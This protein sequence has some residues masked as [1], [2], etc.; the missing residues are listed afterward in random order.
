MGARDNLVVT[1]AKAVEE[2]HARE[3]ALRLA[4]RT[5]AAEAAELGA[6]EVGELE[7]WEEERWT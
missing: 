4:R 7:V 3:R 1:A 5:E 6:I 2:F